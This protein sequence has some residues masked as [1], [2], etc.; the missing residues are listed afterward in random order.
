LGE[1]MSRVEIFRGQARWLRRDLELYYLSEGAGDAVRIE[2]PKG[3]YV[4]TFTTIAPPIQPAPATVL[5]P[6]AGSPRRSRSRRLVVAWIITLAVLGGIAL[7]A[8]LA[9]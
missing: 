1:E 4:P 9:P 2:L 3:G 7:R 5:P 8:L 6:A